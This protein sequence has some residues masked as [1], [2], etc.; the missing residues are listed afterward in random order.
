M[1]LTLQLLLPGSIMDSAGNVVPINDVGARIYDRSTPTIVETVNTVTRSA[2][3]TFSFS[4]ILTGYLPTQLYEVALFEKSSGELLTTRGPVWIESLN[5]TYYSPDFDAMARYG[6][7]K[8]RN[9]EA[10]KR[11]V[12]DNN[13][14]V[15]EW[16]AP[17]TA[18]IT[19]TKRFNASLTTSAITATPTFLRTRS[20]GIH[21]WSLPYNA[22]DRLTSEGTVLYE[23]VDNSVPANRGSITL[24]LGPA[25]S[26]LTVLPLEAKTPTRQE[27]NMIQ[28]FV[29]ERLSTTVPVFDTSNNPVTL[30]GKTLILKIETQQKV[31]LASPPL[32]V[33]ATSFT[34]TPTAEMTNSERTL[35]WALWDVI[36]EGVIAYGTMPVCYVPQR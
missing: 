23:L 22:A 36:A 2:D 28:L 25:S 35:V 15:F 33:G 13:A 14:I 16:P 29:G 31:P 17:G 10:V 19:G 3:G 30:T 11:T 4:P 34:F 21:E 26:S 20:D 18:A 1:P 9:L 6:M 27:G 24:V 32:T 7:T 12:A 8:L 5:G